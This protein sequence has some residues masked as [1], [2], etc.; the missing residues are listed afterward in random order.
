TGSAAWAVTKHSVPA[1]NRDALV[2]N[3]LICLLPWC[4]LS[5]SI[6]QR[7]VDPGSPDVVPD[8][9]ETAWLET[10][11]KDDHQSVEHALQLLCAGREQRL[12]LRA[13]Q[14]E[15]ESC[16][17]RH[18]HDEDSAEHG[19][20]RGAET[21]DDQDRERLDRQQEWETLNAD[22][23]EIDPIQG[24]GDAGDKGRGDESE[25]LVGVQIDAH[26]TGGSIVIADRDKGP[27]DPAAA[28]VEGRKQRGD[29][30]AEAEIGEGRVAVEADAKDLRPLHRNAKS[31]V[32]QPACF[33]DHGVDDE[34]ERKRGDREI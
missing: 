4:R 11:E 31:T 8:A 22:E 12:E 17:F 28:D 13:E 9:H 3:V 16:G 21:A 15:D 32:C 33:Q 5:L 19:T 24:S 2:K 6:T 18:Q 29:R 23:G 34:G 10:Q 30:K 26:D 14:A 1:S 27:S 7:P 25:E 20:E